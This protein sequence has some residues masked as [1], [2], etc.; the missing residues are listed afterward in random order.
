MA[1]SRNFLFN[2]FNFQVIMPHVVR[3]QHDSLGRSRRPT[4]V[5]DHGRLGT[6]LLLNT[7]L[8]LPSRRRFA[9]HL[10]QKYDLNVP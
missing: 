1:N 9:Q 2:N 5:D 10:I 7:A 8:I 4:R 6:V 3:R